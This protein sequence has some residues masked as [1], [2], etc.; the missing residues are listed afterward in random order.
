MVNVLWNYSNPVLASSIENFGDSQNLEPCI[1]KFSVFRREGKIKR[2]YHIKIR[3]NTSKKELACIEA[4][5]EVF[6]GKQTFME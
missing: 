5:F 2:P 6:P 3:W 1:I 4:M